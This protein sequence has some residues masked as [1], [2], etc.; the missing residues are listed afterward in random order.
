VLHN[1][2]RSV[3]ITNE[4]VEKPQNRNFSVYNYL[5]LRRV[6]FTEQ[7]HLDFFDIPNGTLGD[8]G[9]VPFPVSGV[10]FINVAYVKAVPD[11]RG[12]YSGKGGHHAR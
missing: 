8:L 5:I 4:T 11:I 12:E 7:R 3:T 6:N 1:T 10:D 2:S 9:E